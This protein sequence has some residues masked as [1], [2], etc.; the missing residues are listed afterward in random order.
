[1]F[2]STKR[3][4]WVALC[5][6]GSIAVL[7]AD[8]GSTRSW[9]I[10]RF[11]DDTAALTKFASGTKAPT[12][13]DV[14]VLDDEKSFVIEADGS[15]VVTTYLVYE[16]KTQKGADSWNEVSQKW[17]PWNESRPTI[18]ARVIT[19]D[20]KVHLLEPKAVTDSPA[21]EDEADT[22]SDR[23][24]IRGPL[25]AVA[26][27]SIVE[28]EETWTRKLSLPGTG[29]FG[30]FF[31]GRSVPVENSRLLIDLPASV[32]IRYKTILMPDLKPQRKEESGRVRVTFDTGR[33][34]PDDRD[35]DDFWPADTPEYRA[36]IFST[37]SSWKLLADEYAKIVDRTVSAADVKPIV[38]KLIAGKASREE[39]LTAILQY[40]A[41][42]IRYT[43]VEL[44]ESAIIP[45]PPAETLKNKYGDC[46]D[47]AT[48]LVTMLRAADIPA[49]VALLNAGP[50]GEVERDYPGANQF[51]HAIVYV[52]G[53]PDYWIDATDEYARLGEL[54]ESD[55]GRLALIVRPGSDSLTTIPVSSSQ[56]DMLVEKREFYLAENGP[57][58]IVEISEPHGN[59][60]SA[61]RSSYG[62]KEDKEKRKQLAEYVHT[63]YL[64]D[65]LDKVEVSDAA[66]LTKQFQLVLETNAAKRGDTELDSALIAIRL[67]SI[68]ARL[69]EEFQEKKKTEAKN[70]ENEKSKHQRAVDYQ[71]PRNFVT[72]WRYKV[73]PPAG[74][75]PK[76]L[77]KNT[78]VTL[79]PAT[80]TEE[81]SVEKEG[82][83]SA[84]I[85]FDTVK[86]RLTV[87]EAKE[88]GER[89]AEVKE[90]QPILIHFE[91]KAV[92][93]FNSG[94]V[95][96]SFQ[97]YREM[98]ALH[99]KE[100]LHHLQIANAL[101]ASGLGLAARNEAQTAVKLEPTSVLA[102]KTLADI[103]EYDLVGRKFERGSDYKG[104][105]SAFRAAAKLD[106]NDHTVPG[107]L[108]I[109]FEYNPDGDR[110]FPDAKL[111][112]AVT[113]YQTLTPDQLAEIG[114]K[115]NPPFALLYAR[116]F[117]AARKYAEGLN[118]KPAG[119]IVTAETVANGTAAGIAEARK[120][121][122]GEADA[123]K[124]M[125]TVAQ[126]LMKMRIYPAAA[127][128]F[129]AG[130][131][132]DTAAN[133]MSTAALLRKIKF[134]EQIHYADDPNGFAKTY[135]ELSTAPNPTI[136]KILPMM[137]AT[138]REVLK[139]TDADELDSQAKEMSSIR[140]SL[141]R[142]G[143]PIDVMLDIVMQT[144]ETKVEGDDANGY[145][146]KLIVTGK[147]NNSLYV[148][149]EEG[150]FK[151]L[152]SSDKPNSVGLEA[153][154]RVIAN[155][156]A[157]ATVL[158]DWVR[159]D[160]HLAGGDDPLT[161][162]IFP[163]FWTKGK[164]ASADQM[165]LAAAAMLVESKPTAAQG[166]AIFEI[167]KASAKSDSEQTNIALALLTGYMTLANYE[168]AAAVA[169]DLA[170]QFPE[171]ASLFLTQQKALASLGRFKEAEQLSQ[172]RLRRLPDDLDAA[173]SLEMRAVQQGNYELAH[174]LA[175]KIVSSGKAE[176]DDLNSV[177]WNSLLLNKV[178]A[179]DLDA[180]VKAVR[181]NP[182]DMG[183][184]HTLGCVYAEVG[185]TK[186]ARDVLVQA[187]TKLNLAE[188]SS[189]FWYA[190]GRIAEQ[191]GER[192]AA[193]A[194]YSKVTK[195]KTAI[196]IAG[197]SYQLAQTRLK[198]MDAE[199][200]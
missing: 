158:L 17:A 100:A 171:S 62:D 81:F 150:K 82:I 61:Y 13:T 134:H 108:A 111:N 102:Q 104:S 75:Q 3:M 160:E 197:S 199:K 48:L 177:A 5:I 173:R 115:N 77:P 142:N 119:V 181:A 7:R 69:P 38:S 34:D 63:Q 65:K 1:M 124:T 42:E 58:R 188:P 164:Q 67:E 40:M 157:G 161:G 118:P 15:S 71:L 88:M 110:Y 60:E 128:M 72:E 117:V 53:S 149:K 139:N 21:K 127:D 76:G 148:V 106:P 16:I 12:G 45:H 26:I 33:L 153:L 152:D 191:Y 156:L 10:P 9:A 46:K 28:E 92:A 168:K 141:T 87:A 190:F 29:V 144:L 101:L 80:L 136:E 68:F 44:G 151:I 145:R 79:G 186:E 126:T 70:D 132:G 47:K 200:R 130:A 2:G 23:R 172:Q 178:T 184:M 36:L 50:G 162:A 99:P 179:D 89:I 183:V 19:T 85:R 51:D 59:L 137:S 116:D 74:F 121:S 41:R 166:V 91:P 167:A 90:A 143:Y 159:E 6:F 155:N 140:Y 147:T 112:E 27:G 123:K 39:K 138:A 18:H 4:V 113:E 174:D 109:L 133:S 187:M 107:N 129:E 83:V 165:K 22:Y 11:S 37:E 98:I 14:V 20:G 93:L 176:A 120:L 43:G 175:K 52:P 97:A 193:I 169:A 198:A 84:V 122:D 86:D 182:N 131:A 25:P 55:Q 8:S 146:V 64:A 114:L 170:K 56:D 185:K 154:G 189:I 32:S 196:E 180:A 94:K 194:A 57:A 24:V 31:F 195:P 78:K 125:V 105:E 103:L 163:R 95:R 73:V 49:Y 54:P 96:E 66:D 135:F 192:D 30:R 35:D